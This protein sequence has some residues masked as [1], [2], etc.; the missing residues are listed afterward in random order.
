MS[1]EFC[2]LTYIGSMANTREYAVKSFRT[3]W[4]Q[5]WS[6]ASRASVIQGTSRAACMLM[7]EILRLEL[8]ESSDTAETIR[9]MLN[10]AELNGPSLLCDTSLMLWI[11]VLDTVYQLGSNYAVD[12]SRQICNWIRGLWTIGKLVVLCAPLFA[13]CSLS[14]RHVKR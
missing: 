12:A 3:V 14:C 13:T 8:L 10:A 5:A 2:S 11:R 1:F 9:A 4:L 6:L 7:Q